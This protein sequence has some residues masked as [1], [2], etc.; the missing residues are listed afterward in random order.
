MEVLLPGESADV[1]TGAVELQP[2]DESSVRPMLVEYDVPT[3]L[4]RHP[5]FTYHAKY[6]A[7]WD[8]HI[9]LRLEG[10]PLQVKSIRLDDR[11]IPIDLAENKASLVSIR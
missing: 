5:L 8:A 3:A 2:S 7:T 1:H 9:A 6:Q 10:V 11:T 4:M